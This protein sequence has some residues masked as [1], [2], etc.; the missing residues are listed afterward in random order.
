MKLI[1]VCYYGSMSTIIGS[2]FI[3]FFYSIMQRTINILNW[4]KSGITYFIITCAIFGIISFIACVQ[5][6]GKE[7]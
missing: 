1:K 3:Y 5:T 7:N 6:I 4:S 2:G